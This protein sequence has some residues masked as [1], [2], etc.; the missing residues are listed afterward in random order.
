M[1]KKSELIQVG[2][3]AIG[4]SENILPDT[5]DLKGKH[6][7][8]FF[9]DGTV[10]SYEFKDEHILAWKT[11][12]AHENAAISEETYRT[13]SPRKNIYF[14]DYIK[15]GSRATSMSLVLDFDVGIVTELIGSLPTE[16]DARTDKLARVATGLQQ[17]AVEV[18]FKFGS[19]NKAFTSET[20]KL[21]TTTEMIGKRVKYVYSQKDAYEHI[22][23]NENLY[24]WHCLSGIEKGM[25]DT[26]RCHYFKIKQNLY[27]FVWREK[28]V[29]TLGVVLV[30]LQSMK[31][32]GKIFGY[33]S[34]NFKA[35]TNFPIG[36][37]AQV[38][39][40]TS[41]T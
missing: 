5:S 30:D 34:D 8:L 36:A 38:A 29:P 39:N 9:E 41:Y 18:E 10:S 3:L 12:N 21:E 35:L 13:T 6:F 37:F 31:T 2:E 33:E 20:P 14:V 19:I 4:F 11:T 27:L 23:L 16:M 22:Y 15:K 26:D 17:T 7:E 28:F 24:S 25:A 32:T 1:I 40:T